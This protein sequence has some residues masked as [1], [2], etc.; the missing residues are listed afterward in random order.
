LIQPVLVP[1]FALDNNG[2]AALSLPTAPFE[3]AITLE[4]TRGRG[5][6]LPAHDIRLGFHP[7][8]LEHNESTVLAFKWTEDLISQNA[9]REVAGISQGDVDEFCAR[10]WSFLSDDLDVSAFWSSVQSTC[11]FSEHSGKTQ[12]GDYRVHMHE[13]FIAYSKI[14]EQDQ[15]TAS[16]FMT[17]EA[18]SNMR[19]PVHLPSPVQPD[20]E[21]FVIAW[22]LEKVPSSH[23]RCTALCRLNAWLSWLRA[24]RNWPEFSSPISIS[25][26]P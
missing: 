4:A 9:N 15:D 26:N 17:A 20:T 25:P 1:C 12:W 11:G 14:P 21:F 5:T 10:F 2:G 18:F 23:D 7:K 3:H 19:L 6:P 8:G 16:P 24:S 22:A 13:N